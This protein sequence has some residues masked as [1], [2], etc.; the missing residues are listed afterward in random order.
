MSRELVLV[1][2]FGPLDE[3]S[4]VAHRSYI[5]GFSTRAVDQCRQ[6]VYVTDAAGDQSTS[7]LP[8]LHRDD[9]ACRSSVS[10]GPPSPSPRLS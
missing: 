9:R 6:W 2:E 3:L 5:D 8:A 10:T 1:S 7:L 4:N